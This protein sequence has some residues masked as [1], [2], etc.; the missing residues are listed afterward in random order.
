M[1]DACKLNIIKG[2]HKTA[3]IFTSLQPVHEKKNTEKSIATT[4]NKL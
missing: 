2:D 3:I 4:I 1:R